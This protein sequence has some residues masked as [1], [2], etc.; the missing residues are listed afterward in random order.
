MDEALHKQ[1]RGAAPLEGCAIDLLLKT[2]ASKEC[3]KHGYM[4]DRNGQNIW[5][6]P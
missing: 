6:R 4:Q 1:A 3:E 2:H 5:E